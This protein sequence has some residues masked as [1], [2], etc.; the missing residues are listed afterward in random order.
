MFGTTYDHDARKPGNRP[1]NYSFGNR[2]GL[3]KVLEAL[4]YEI[5]TTLIALA[6]ANKRLGTTSFS[7]DVHVL[8]RQLAKAE[9]RYEDRLRLKTALRREGLL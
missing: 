8:D 1:L 3:V 7:V 5:P 4:G 2:E 6:A 9:I